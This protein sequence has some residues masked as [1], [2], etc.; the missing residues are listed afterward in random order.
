VFPNLVDQLADSSALS[1]PWSELAQPEA[2][3]RYRS[4]VRRIIR[5]LRWELYR[6]EVRRIVGRLPLEP[7]RDVEWAEPSIRHP[8][9]ETAVGDEL[10]RQPRGS[11]K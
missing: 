1:G 11:P 2:A 10:V 6:T 9:E 5:R 8:G 4:R 7:K 3:R